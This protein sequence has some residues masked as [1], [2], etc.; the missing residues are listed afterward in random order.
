M[1]TKCLNLTLDKMSGLKT[2]VSP[3]WLF[4]FLCYKI[5]IAGAG[6]IIPKTV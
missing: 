3:V 6:I 4:C 5:A 2:N 1:V